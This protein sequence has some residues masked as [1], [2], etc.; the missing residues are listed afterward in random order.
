MTR[1]KGLFIGILVAG[2]LAAC[3]P[4][5]GE[6]ERFLVYFDELSANVTP[7]AAG[8]VA[9]AVAKAKASQARS[10]RIEGRASA[11]GSAAANQKLSE[12]RAQAVANELQKD[13]LD[14]KTFRQVSVG[15]TGSG[16]TSVADRRVDIVLER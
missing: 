7:Q 4:Q 16:D 6:G 14:P 9:D 2:T 1:F 12:S 11:T 8:V 15:Q 5:A 13:G 10:I 3:M